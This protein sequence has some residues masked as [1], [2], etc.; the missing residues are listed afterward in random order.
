[1]RKPSIDHFFQRSIGWEKMIT[2]ASW[3]CAGLRYEAPLPQRLSL[4]GA[5]IAKKCGST[6]KLA[7]VRLPKLGK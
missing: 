5:K 3:P 1:M 2:D 6:G 4:L 7:V